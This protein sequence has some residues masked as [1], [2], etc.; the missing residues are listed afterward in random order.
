MDH[1]LHPYA[2]FHFKIMNANI[3]IDVSL[4][5]ILL[6]IYNYEIV[7]EIIV[8][9]FLSGFCFL[10]VIYKLLLI[11]YENSFRCL[12]LILSTN[13]LIS[14]GLCLLVHLLS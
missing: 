14:S 11:L 3:D 7:I 2:K 5:I 13:F 10:C 12:M 4:T 8:F 9:F 1:N 6:R